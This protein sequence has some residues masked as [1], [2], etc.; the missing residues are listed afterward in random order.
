MLAR[1]ANR[2]PMVGNRGGISIA[3]GAMDTVEPRP[4]APAPPPWGTFPAPPWPRFLMGLTRAIPGWPVV[5]QLAFPLRRLAR[6]SLEGPV[7]AVLWGQ[8]L[9]FHPHGNISEGRL[10]FMPENWD[11]RERRLLDRVLVPGTVFLD[12]GSNFGAYTWW[13]LSRLGRECTVVALE[14]DPELNARLH[15][16][17]ATNGWDH[18]TVLPCAAGAEEG[19][20]VLHIHGK[21]RGENTLLEV[22]GAVDAGSVEVPVRPLRAVVREQGLS[23]IDI[24]KIDIE[25]L[26]PPVLRSFFADDPG[27]LAPTWIFCEW[28]DTPEHRGLEAFLLEQGYQLELRTKLNMVLRRRDDT[29]GPR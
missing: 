2:A 16:N 1:G 11:K 3:C 9:R 6:R 22:E 20:A 4:A 21:N 23:R 10:L 12:V 7:D 24:L 26:E 13:V 18:V 27:P 17:L 19:R 14:P 15:F 29:G 8:R 28:K 5:K 25:G